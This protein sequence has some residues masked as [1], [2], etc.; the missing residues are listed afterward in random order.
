VVGVLGFSPRTS[1]SYFSAATDMYA[2]LEKHPLNTY[3]DYTLRKFP[4]VNPVMLA[5]S[6]V[7]HDDIKFEKKVE[8]IGRPVE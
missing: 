1:S 4:E 6:L 5:K 3:L 7:Y 2:L 8:Y